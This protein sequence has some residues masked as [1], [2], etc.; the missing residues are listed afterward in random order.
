MT[1]IDKIAAAIA[2]EDLTPQGRIVCRYPDDFSEREIARYRA[3][4]RA[5]IEAMKEPSLRVLHAG[6]EMRTPITAVLDIWRAMISA[7]LSED[8]GMGKMPIYS[9]KNVD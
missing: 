9:G 1:M 8:T 7:A 3:K 4:A 6:I 5:A 2:W